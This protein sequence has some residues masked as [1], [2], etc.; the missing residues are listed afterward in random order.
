MQDVR[1]RFNLLFNLQRV[2]KENIFSRILPLSIAIDKKSVKQP[3]EGDWCE[4]VRMIVP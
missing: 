2:L 3:L 4:V 1:S